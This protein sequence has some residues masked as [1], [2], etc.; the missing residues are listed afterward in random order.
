MNFQHPHING[1]YLGGELSP[2]QGVYAVLADAVAHAGGHKRAGAALW[3][4]LPIEG[5]ARRLRDCLNTARRECLHPHEV[6]Q[7]LGLA[8]AAGWHGGMAWMCAAA[9]YGQGAALGGVD[10]VAMA[11]QAAAHELELAQRYAAS[12]AERAA[13][14]ARLV[15]VQQAAGAAAAGAPR[16]VN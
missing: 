15:A 4:E 10:E 11:L 14:L 1:I 5:A 8:R 2:A 13:Q 6:V 7:L 9:G 12:A 16:S 3:P